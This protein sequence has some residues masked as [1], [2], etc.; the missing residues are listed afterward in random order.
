MTKKKALLLFKADVLP[1]VVK[2][3][4]K[5]DKPAKDQAWNDYTDSLCKAG[6]ITVEQYNTW[7]HPYN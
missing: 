5:N 2:Q 1:V 6:F 3:Y 7:S 4:G